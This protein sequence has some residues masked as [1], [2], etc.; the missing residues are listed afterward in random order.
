M[1][2]MKKRSPMMRVASIMLVLCLALSCAVFG[3]LAKYTSDAT[4]GTST[5]S[6]AKWSFTVEGTDIATAETFTANL[7]GETLLDSD[8]ATAETDVASGKIAPGTS[9]KI[10]LNVA[11]KSDVNATY[12]V[13][14]TANEAGVPLQW[15]LDGSTWKDSIDALDFDSKDEA[16]NAGVVAMN[17]G[18]ASDT[19]YWQWVYF[20]DAEGDTADTAL[21]IAASAQPT[22]TVKVTATQVD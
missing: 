20:V 10:E 7:F 14:F 17:D 6:V 2:N 3:T 21:G 12:A 19:L 8:I 15:S 22:V 11:N 16:D 9:G 13:D 1:M 18:T 4:S 5:A